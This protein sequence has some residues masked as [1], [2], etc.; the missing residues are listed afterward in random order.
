MKYSTKIMQYGTE[1]EWK[2]QLCNAI[3]DVTKLVE[4]FDLEPKFVQQLE[5][6]AKKYPI[7][8]TPYY[9]SLVKNFDMQDPIVRQ[10]FPD[11]LEVDSQEGGVPDPLAE[12]DDSPVPGL[13]HRYPDRVLLVINNSCAVHCRHCMRKRNWGNGWQLDRA[14][15]KRVVQYLQKNTAV[16]EVLLSGGEPLLVDDKFLF[17]VLQALREVPHIEII[18]VASRLPVTL[19]QRFTVKFCQ[20]LAEFGPIWLATHFNHPQEITRESEIVVNRLLQVGIP[21]VNQTVLLRGVND[22]AEVLR[23]LF[24]SLLKIKIKPYYLFHGDPVEGAMHFRTGV[25]VGQDIMEKLQGKM[26]G[27]ALPVFAIDLPDG[28]GKV[29]LGGEKNMSLKENVYRSYKGEYCKY[30]DSNGGKN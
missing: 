24:T 9:F 1:Y 22:D 4:M 18:R 23:T 5:R 19:P 26:S 6:V 2:Q 10:F 29:R 28:K 13:T 14:G 11:I 27:L 3:S 15:V 25:Q 17:F 21:V 30:N 12:E 7:L 8:V 20:A 16:R